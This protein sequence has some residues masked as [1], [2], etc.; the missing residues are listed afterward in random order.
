MT[1]RKYR[2]MQSP[3]SSIETRE[4]WIVAVV[5]LIVMLM[6][7]GGAWVTPVALKDIAAEVGGTRSVPALASALVWFGSGFGGIL[8][9]RL[10]DTIGIRWTA[11]GGALMIAVGL[12]ISTLGPPVPLW[13]GH[14]LFIGLLGLAGINAPMYIYVSR[15]FD[16]RR[17]SALAL[18]SSGGYLAGALWPP[19]FEPFIAS[20]GWRQTMLTYAVVEIVV[21]LPLAL[22]FLRH[23]P[24]VILPVVRSG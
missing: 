13:I 12:L 6:A 18:I 15:W 4:S 1:S 11:F 21:I 5:A 2:S 23:P 22:I 9:G 19:I 16:R 10:A 24:E 14:G 7:F 3:S 20:F 17:G 8:M